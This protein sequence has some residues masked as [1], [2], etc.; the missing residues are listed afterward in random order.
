MRVMAN[1]ATKHTKKARLLVCIIATLISGQ[2]AL[3]ATQPVSLKVTAFDP[4]NGK[5][6]LWSATTHEEKTIE[7]VDSILNE[8]RAPPPGRYHGPMDDGSYYMIDIGYENNSHSECKVQ[9]TGLRIVSF[10]DESRRN[11]LR[12]GWAPGL[13]K[14]LEKMRPPG[15]PTFKIPVTD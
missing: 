8:L 7:R 13:T 1:N 6:K 2:M 14:E 3:A 4:L 5:G 15:S 9:R 12:S 10:T 11:G